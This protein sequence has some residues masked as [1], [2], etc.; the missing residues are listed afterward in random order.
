MDFYGPEFM[1]GPLTC[2]IHRITHREAGIE[3]IKFVVTEENIQDQTVVA[4]G[5]FHTLQDALQKIEQRFNWA[6]LDEL[7]EDFDSVGEY[8]Q[9]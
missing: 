9:G 8:H 1:K 6:D 4:L 5:L 2:R 3:T 7:I